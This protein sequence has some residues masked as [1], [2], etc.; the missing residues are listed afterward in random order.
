MENSK[1][2]RLLSRVNR[3]LVLGL[4]LGVVLVAFVVVDTVKFNKETANIKEDIVGYITALAQ[5]NG[6]V[7]TTPVGMAITNE[8]RESMRTELYDILEEYCADPALAEN[9]TVY[10]GYDS[11]GVSSWLSV[12]CNHTAG[13]RLVSVEVNQ[14]NGNFKLDF[15]RQGYNYAHVQLNNLPITMTVEEGGRNTTNIFL[16]AGPSYLI[17]HKYDTVEDVWV[18]TNERT[19]YLSGTLYLTRVEGEWK[20]L[21]SDFYTKNKPEI[22]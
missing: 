10:E 11:I 7:E 18:V 15:E 13:F 6:K 8:D 22:E 5:L 12:W 2:K 4:V 3:G 9:I 19:V 16:G 17:D 20:I 21:M 14:D 1:L